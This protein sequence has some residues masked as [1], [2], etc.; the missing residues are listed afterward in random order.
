[1]TPRVRSFGIAPSD[2]AQTGAAGEEAEI[3]RFVDSGELRLPGP[4]SN[5]VQAALAE[6]R[7][8]W[9]KEEAARLADAEVVWAEKNEKRM[10]IARIAAQ[11]AESALAQLQRELTKAEA[12]LAAREKELV[13]LQA[14]YNRE[15]ER[16][17]E[18]PAA[19]Q[20]E[21]AERD[22]KFERRMKIGLRLARDLAL[23]VFVLAAAIIV[24]QR[25]APIIATMLRQETGAHS[26]V[27][28]LLERAGVPLP[29]ADVGPQALVSTPVVKLHAE[30]DSGASVVGRLWRNETVVPLAHSGSWVLVRI[31]AAPHQ[32][33]GWVAASALKP[34]NVPLSAAR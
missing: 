29:A 17:K 1:M 31:G 18:S 20:K 25:A 6:A 30:P 3:R 7:Q 27:R 32:Q 16:W 4:P 2:V 21:Q 15:R 33:Q 14:L 26:H 22:L 8:H 28:P 9:H 13:Q 24:G 12:N 11:R 19:A 23:T 5:V 10:T 34:V